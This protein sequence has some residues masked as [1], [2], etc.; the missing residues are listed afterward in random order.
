M[1]GCSTEESKQALSFVGLGLEHGDNFPAEDELVA[2][3]SVICSVHMSL[4][5]L[6]HLRAG[7]FGVGG[8]GHWCSAALVLTHTG[9][10]ASLGRVLVKSYVGM[11][12][13][14]SSC[15]LLQS[16]DQEP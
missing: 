12:L 2:P 7:P 9:L 5:L 6:C 8:G 15:Y 13:N 16:L 11:R 14:R 4:N 1:L 3:V 10:R